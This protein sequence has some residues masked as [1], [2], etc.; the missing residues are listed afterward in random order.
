MA[1]DPS[2][3][4]KCVI[5]SLGLEVSGRQDIVIDLS[6]PEASKSLKDKP[7][8][9]KE[10]SK[11]RMK[12]QFRVQHEVLSGLKYIQ[13]VKRKGM[14]VGKDEEMLVSFWA[15]I[16]VFEELTDGP[17]QGSYAPNTE[18]TPVYE[19]KCRFSAPSSLRTDADIAAILQSRKMK[20]PPECLPAA[21]TLP[22][23]VSSMTMIMLTCSSNGLSTSLRT[24]SNRGGTHPR[25][26]CLQNMALRKNA[27]YGL[28]A[29]PY[30]PFRQGGDGGFQIVISGL[31]REEGQN[32]MEFHS[33][34][35]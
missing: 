27:Y 25:A 7:F 11:F 26:R 17:S 6:G 10:G 8:T 14:K 21:T 12:A 20:P 34:L 5:T 29:S 23:P 2:D 9:I 32:T 13:V 33:S 28:S 4:R 30:Y 18:T 15:S 3:K 35:P 31:S 22:F 1:V 16:E 19:K 24:G